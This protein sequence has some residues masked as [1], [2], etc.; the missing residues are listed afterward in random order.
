LRWNR[1]AIRSAGLAVALALVL[2]LP[3]QRT[4]RAPAV[5]GQA[6]AQVVYLPRPAQLVALD[7]REGQSVR[8]GATLAQLRAPELD[9]QLAAAEQQAAQL[10]WQLER[11]PFD[12]Q[13][14]ALGPAL[15]KRRAGARETV[16]GLRA[17][18]ERLILRAPFAGRVVDLASGLHAG[19]WLKGGEPLMGVVGTGGSKGDAF[20]G[21]SALARLAPGQ[22][23]AFVATLPEQPTVHCRVQGI[24]RLNLAALDEAYVASIYGGDVP[25]VRR[26]D[27]SIAPLE[28]TF[29][30]RFGACDAVRTLA[31]ELPG[32]AIVRGQ[33]QSLAVRFAHWLGAIARREMGF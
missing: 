3:W 21:E 32:Q 14:R 11:Q 1:Q 2:G 15:R 22:P 5:L 16:A 10:Q 24:D 7:V 28:S 26:P 27:G 12:D 4:V 31:R 29:R 25:S 19:E 17:E 13:L 33:G 8:A 6:Q 20:V 9:Y 23:V 30:V 18:R